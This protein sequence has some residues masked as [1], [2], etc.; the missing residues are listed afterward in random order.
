M[1]KIG[2]VLGWAVPEAWFA[3]LVRKEFPDTQHVFVAAIPDV[4]ECLEATGPFD[5]IVG[6]SLGSL[7]L[8]GDVA[9]AERLGRVALLAPTFAFPKEKN[10]GGRV[11]VVQLR[12]LARWLRRDPQAAIADFYQ[13]AQL[14][15]V[16][17]EPP[18]AAVLADL[19]WG[20]ERLEHNAVPPP[21]PVGWS[22]WC[23]SDDP[24]LEA[25][26][27]HELS[28]EIVVVPGGGH[29]PAALL[30]AFAKEAL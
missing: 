22:A 20:L 30:R 6:Y 24:L 10:V 2:W 3:P 26:H 12:Q 25:V 1:R 15:V 11:A 8:L 29:H 19:A 16:L 17:T 9:R 28:P 18:S 23:G 21:L 7:L 4:F 13:R 27:L 14:D 5:W